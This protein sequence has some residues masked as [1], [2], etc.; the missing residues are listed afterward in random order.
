MGANLSGS[1]RYS[2]CCALARQDGSL[3]TTGGI[4]VFLWRWWRRWS[5]SPVVVRVA[6]P[7]TRA[8]RDGYAQ[9]RVD[10]VS[11]AIKAENS[12]ME[13]AQSVMRILCQSG[14]TRSLASLYFILGGVQ[15]VDA[16]EEDETGP[17]LRSLLI[18]VSAIVSNERLCSLRNEKFEEI[19]FDGC[20]NMVAASGMDRLA[21]ALNPDKVAANVS[22][23][24]VGKSCSDGRTER[25]CKKSVQN[26]AI[27]AKKLLE[28]TDFNGPQGY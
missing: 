26:C 19:D 4:G 9:P 14:A 10:V 25:Q 21:K 3:T 24:E 17:S 8:W 16:G 12:S 15:V 2:R 6:S 27:F 23:F 22:A 5:R 18:M 7:V 11:M 1:L 20:Q 28:E 13:P